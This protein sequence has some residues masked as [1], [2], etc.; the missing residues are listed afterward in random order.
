MQKWA[1]KSILVNTSYASMVSLEPQFNKLGAEGWELVAIVSQ[2]EG[3][4][5]G[6]AVFKRPW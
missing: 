3:Q 1:Y 4:H 2:Y 6:T 5:L